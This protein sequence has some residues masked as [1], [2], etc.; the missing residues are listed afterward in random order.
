MKFIHCPHRRICTWCRFK[1]FVA[2]G[3]AA[4]SW[5]SINFGIRQDTWILYFTLS[6]THISIS[7][8]RCWCYGTITPYGRRRNSQPSRIHIAVVTLFIDL[9][10]TDVRRTVSAVSVHNTQTH[11]EC[12]F[13]LHAKL[14]STSPHRSDC[15]YTQTLEIR[16]LVDPHG[17]YCESKTEKE[18]ST[19]NRESNA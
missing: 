3:E 17:I 9:V 5:K 19:T 7:L 2:D 4:I 13:M 10:C 16:I 11:C 18:R 14:C 15:N 8:Y 6:P 12:N 1:R